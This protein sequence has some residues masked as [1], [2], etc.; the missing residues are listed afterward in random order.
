M[1]QRGGLSEWINIEFQ[2]DVVYIGGGVE[3]NGLCIEYGS[4]CNGF[5][6][7]SME[8]GDKRVG[9]QC[10]WEITEMSE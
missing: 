1:N 5:F 4:A 2:G 8:C 7:V 6:S 3:K 9:F 10:S